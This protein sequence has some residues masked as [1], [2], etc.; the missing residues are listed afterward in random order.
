[1]WKAYLRF[2]KYLLDKIQEG[3]LYLLD[4][5]GV[6]VATLLFATFSINP[7]ICILRS[8]SPILNGVFIGI[9][10]VAVMGR[11]TLQDK[12]KNEI[13][14]ALAM[15]MEVTKTRHA[16][17]I[18]L[19][20]LVIP[21]LIRLDALGFVGTFFMLV[22]AYLWC[23]KIRERDR[24]PFWKPAEGKQELAMERGN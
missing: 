3:Y 6:Y 4:R 21:D 12:G 11:Y 13:F 9:V 23:V 16:F 5:T 2:D 15:M 22:Y 18:M 10:G 17:Q 8:S 24:K 14:N 20:L 19:G 7:G 1:M